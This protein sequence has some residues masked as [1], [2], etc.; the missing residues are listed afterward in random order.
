MEEKKTAE[1]LCDRFVV[2]VKSIDTNKQGQ[3]KGKD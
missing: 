1:Y 3:S 2:F